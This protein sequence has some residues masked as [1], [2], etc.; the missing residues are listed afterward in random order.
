MRLSYVDRS[1]KP[2]RDELIAEYRVEPNKI[3][4]ERVCEHLAGESSIGTWT[5]LGTMK[6]SI[7]KKLKPHVYYINKKTKE[8]RIAYPIDLFEPGNMPQILS[9]IAGNIFGMKAVKSLRL[10]DIHFP[11]KLVNSF[12]GPKFGIQGIRNMTGIKH[13]PLVGTIIKPKVG[14]NPEQ[15]AKVAFNAWIGGCDAVK[16]DENLG[17]MSFNGFRKR[18]K[19]TLRLKRKAE[20]ITGEVKI[21]MP[22]LTAETGEMLRRADYVIN[23]GGNYIMVD[24]LTSGFAAIQTIRNQNFSVPIHAHRAMHAA[25]TKSSTHGISMLVLAKIFRLIGVDTLHIGTA[26]IGKMIETKKEVKIIEEEIEKIKV[27]ANSQENVL[28]QNW[29]NIKPV[30]AVASGGLHPGMVP[31]LMRA[32]GNDIVIQM[33][34]GIHGNPLGTEKG[35]MAARQAVD[36]TLAK[37]P[38]DKYA[39]AHYELKRAID[40]WGWMR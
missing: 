17:N 7:A 25:L 16:D 38:L 13:R 28:A 36:A 11:K 40:T 12:M 20:K 6:K 37:V 10:Q 24:I 30:F 33:G 14:L 23:E 19:A 31:P 18:V 9:S 5:E 35:A 1:Y 4:M 22:N 34:G 26:G 15:H 27:K 3:S 2:R 32:M 39:T 29:Y 21:Y 8:V